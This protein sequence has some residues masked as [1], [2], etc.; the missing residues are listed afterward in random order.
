M[1]ST[2]L[3]SRWKL[4]SNNGTS[5]I[6]KDCKDYKVDRKGYEKLEYEPKKYG[7]YFCTL[8]AMLQN[9]D[10]FD[11]KTFWVN[12]FDLERV[13]NIFSDEDLDIYLYA[14]EN[15]KSRNR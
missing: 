15:I 9:W 4:R 11:H 1:I 13:L 2:F 6:K 5:Y 8:D 7:R 3:K 12:A 10:K 14:K